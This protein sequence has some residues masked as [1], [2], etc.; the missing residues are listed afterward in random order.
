MLLP[1]DCEAYLPCLRSRARN[2]EIASRAVGTGTLRV[3]SGPRCGPSFR[4]MSAAGTFLVRL[5][6]TDRTSAQRV[7]ARATLRST[8]TRSVVNA[9]KQPSIRSVASADVIGVIV[10]RSSARLRQKGQGAQGKAAHGDAAPGEVPP[11]WGSVDAPAVLG[12]TRHRQ[13]VG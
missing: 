12:P 9:R 1:L 10:T 2:S 7:A 4:K 11:K 13:L 8:V 5:A 6:S 3:T